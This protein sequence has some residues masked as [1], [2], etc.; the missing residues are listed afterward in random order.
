MNTTQSILGDPTQPASPLRNLFFKEFNRLEPVLRER[1]SKAVGA[2]RSRGGTRLR[3]WSHAS[4]QGHETYAIAMILEKLLR[5]AGPDLSFEVVGTDQDPL[6]LLAATRGLYFWDELK[7]IPANYMG[8]HWVRGIGSE[9]GYVQAQV[10]LKSRCVFKLYN[11]SHTPE[12]GKF[13]LIFSK[14]SLTGAFDSFLEPYGAVFDADTLP[15]SS[16][17]SSGPLKSFERPIRVLCVDDSP[18]VLGFLKKVLTTDSG[19]EVVATARNGLEATEILRSKR[20]DIMTLDIHMPE[21]TGLEYLQKNFG[22]KHPP[23]VMLTSV[24]REDLESGLAC[25]Q[26]GVKDYIEKS[27]H[28]GLIS[29]AD[30]IRL[31]LR[32]AYQESQIEQMQDRIEAMNG[33]IELSKSFAQPELILR[34]ENKLRVIFAN[35]NRIESLKDLL[36]KIKNAQPA[37]LVL[38]HQD[39]NSPLEKKQLMAAFEELRNCCVMRPAL[40]DGVSAI[41]QGIYFASFEKRLENAKI[42]FKGRRISSMLLG[43]VSESTTSKIASWINWTQ[44]KLL[45]EDQAPDSSAYMALRQLASDVLPATGFIHLA[46]QY[47]KK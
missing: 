10:S 47:L 4:G 42:C 25:L 33:L 14:A 29:Q 44:S 39:G 45:I 24:A 3:V 5:D 27:N 26:S 36:K 43:D 35:L 30:E 13:D 38:F 17:N 40:W 11:V 18:I 1:I 37:T 9:A 8:N 2:V 28:A 23:V 32:C 31:K 15:V 34:P 6:S 22:P 16:R 21:Q 19:F 46:D 7:G 12:L 20:V 41:S